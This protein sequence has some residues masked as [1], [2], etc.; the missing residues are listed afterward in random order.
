MIEPINTLKTL[1]QIIAQGVE[2]TPMMKQYYEI[3]KQY[4]D[5]LLL[6]RM[7]DF[8]EVFFDDARETSRLL[9]IT[10]THR[11]QLGDTPGNSASC[12]ADLY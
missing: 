12:G 7:G 6:F 1:D 11:G 3:K 8:Y 4:P 2:L 5:M 9:N 10:L